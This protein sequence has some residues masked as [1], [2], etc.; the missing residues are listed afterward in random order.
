MW[1]RALLLVTGLL[2]QT[3]A[4]AFE[5]PGCEQTDYPYWLHSAA[6]L[7]LIAG[8]CTSIEVSRLYYLRAYHA[9]L[10]AEGRAMAGLIPYERRDSNIDFDSYRV[11]MALVETLTPVW[12]PEDGDRLHFLNAEYAR[13]MEIAELRLRGYDLQAD[14]L[15]G[16]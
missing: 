10:V 3:H 7:R 14:R 8:T 5:H 1:K 15:E 4:I 16:E 2:F 13:R 9:D 6:E 12:L 11:Y